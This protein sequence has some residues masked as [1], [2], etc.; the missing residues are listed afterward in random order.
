MWETFLRAW[1]HLS[2]TGK[3]YSG[4]FRI[5]KI[6]GDNCPEVSARVQVM[7]LCYM[8]RV[9]PRSIARAVSLQPL[10]ESS[11]WES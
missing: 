1:A 5:L 4:A 3:T 6:I 11:S 9:P 7:G 10:H 2:T 8:F